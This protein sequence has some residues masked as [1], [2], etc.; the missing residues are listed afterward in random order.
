MAFDILP[1][2]GVGRVRLGMTVDEV[3][4]VLGKE[5]DKSSYNDVEELYFDNFISVS[6]RGGKVFQIGATR[7]A[8]GILYNGKDIFSDD[9]INVL[10]S[11]EM[12]AGGA[13]ESFGFIVFLPLGVSLTGF[14][15]GDL[16]NKA[17]TVAVL[18][19]WQG[20]ADELVPIS[21]V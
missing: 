6:F 5:E 8:K 3:R 21:F 20:A 14:H 17:V 9:P 13:F 7:R 4:A 16:D 19:E 18:E 1:T 2:Q 12:D 11:F 15:D 10:R